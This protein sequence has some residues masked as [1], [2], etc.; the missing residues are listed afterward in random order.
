MEG[1]VGLHHQTN[2]SPSPPP[3]NPHT[4]THQK[5]SY[6]A[7]SP[8][9][10]SGITT[11]TLG[12]PPSISY[13]AWSLT[14]GLVGG[15]IAGVLIGDYHLLRRKR[16]PTAALYPPP[17]GGA[18]AGRVVNPA[19]VLA[20]AAAFVPF[21]FRGVVLRALG[22]E[23]CVG[24][25]FLGVR[26]SGWGVGLGREREGEGERGTDIWIQIGLATHPRS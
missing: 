3:P 26:G 9:A 1:S 12:S 19:G 14:S 15:A 11:T 6:E 7:L 2:D 8:P 17:G 23:W 18:G 21:A 25:G 13:H 20:L 4:H 16:L 22:D 5:H 24:S 10:L